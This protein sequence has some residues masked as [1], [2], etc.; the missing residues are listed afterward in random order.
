MQARLQ[1]L[2]ATRMEIVELFARLQRNY[3]LKIN[4]VVQ[5]DYYIGYLIY[6]LNIIP[7]MDNCQQHEPAKKWSHIW[8]DY[9]NYVKSIQKL[10]AVIHSFFSKII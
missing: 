9:C 7:W 3:D 6:Y 2:T 10:T 1:G 8:W 4:Q 5:G